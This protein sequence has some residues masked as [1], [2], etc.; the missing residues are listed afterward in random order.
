[1]CFSTLFFTTIKNKISQ[2]N[3]CFETKTFHVFLGM[4]WQQRHQD[5]K[6]IKFSEPNYHQIIFS[7]KSSSSFSCFFFN[8][9]SISHAHRWCHGSWCGTNFFP[10]GSILG[11]GP[12]TG[13]ELS[14]CES[15]LRG[16]QIKYTRYVSSPA[17]CRLTVCCLLCVQS[18]WY[19]DLQSAGVT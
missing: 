3:V 17:S 9:K 12:G 15:F 11:S 7:P 6:W 13:S 4:T 10:V 18:S 19:Q 1:M 5:C 16:L 14:Q 2:Q 8:Q